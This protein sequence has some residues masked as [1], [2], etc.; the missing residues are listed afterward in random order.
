[1]KDLS[2][3]AFTQYRNTGSH[4]ATGSASNK[5]MDV[6]VIE[7]SDD[8]ATVSVISSW[9]SET[10]VQLLCIYKRKSSGQ[11]NYCTGTVTGN[12]GVP[13]LGASTY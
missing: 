5:E 8:A 2:P 4:G 7:E 11:T 13:Q 9:N 6:T 12:V 10:S 3:R 1:M